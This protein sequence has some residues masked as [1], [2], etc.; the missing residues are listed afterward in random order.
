MSG[1]AILGASKAG[2]WLECPA[3][4]RL[5][6][7]IPRKSSDAAD[8]GTAAHALG[9]ICLREEKQAVEYLGESFGLEENLFEADV[10]MVEA[11][12]VY[13]DVV[14]EYLVNYPGSALHVEKKFKLDWLHSG[15]WGTADAVIEIPFLK[16]VVI[17]LK[18]GVGKLVDPANN[19]QAMYYGLGASHGEDYGTCE[20]VIVQ[21]RAAGEKIKRW[22][23]SIEALESWGRDVLLPG[24]LATENVSAQPA[25][26][27]H[28][29]QYFCSAKPFCPA[30]RKKALEA[31]NIPVGKDNWPTEVKPK[32]PPVANMSPEQLARA[33]DLADLVEPWLKA[34]KEAAFDAESLPGWKKVEGRGTRYW[35]LKDNEVLAKLTK[36]RSDVYDTKLKSVSQ[37][38][39]M[40]KAAGGNPKAE[41]EGLIEVKKGVVLARESDPRPAITQADPFGGVDAEL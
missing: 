5:T 12:Q 33:L 32:L 37:M 18:Y 9:E 20:I 19:P 8:L 14:R 27:Q 13:L 38:E 36:Y 39:K 15:L 7:D 2:L 29:A 35:G 11:V 16:I 1:H 31:A 30:L 3:M 40:I 26:G 25:P 28:C 17:D 23:T 21:P 41:L 22:E 24:A 10:E 4:P 6:K 34:V